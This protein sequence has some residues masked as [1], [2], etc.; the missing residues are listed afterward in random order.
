MG[1]VVFTKVRGLAKSESP[2]TLRVLGP[3]QKLLLPLTFRSN[4]PLHLHSIITVDPSADPTKKFLPLVEVLD[5]QMK[6]MN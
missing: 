3:L 2:R 4:V 1:V 5:E 6:V